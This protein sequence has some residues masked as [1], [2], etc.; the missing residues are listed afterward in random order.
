MEKVCKKCG[1]KLSDFY[2]TSMLGCENCYRTFFDELQPVLTKLHGK[3]EHIGKVPK[4]SAVEKEMLYEYKRL[5]KNKEV[6]VL[7]G[8][9]QD[10]SELDE[11]I[12]ALAEELAERGLK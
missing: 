10:A 5:L 2:K 8:R 7:E 11:D 12:S 3:T 1:T 4:I 9:F 6:A